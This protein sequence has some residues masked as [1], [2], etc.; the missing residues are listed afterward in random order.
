MTMASRSIALMVGFVLVWILTEAIIGSLLNAYSPLQIVWMHYLMQ[1]VIWGLV[2]GV[3]GPKRLVRTGKLTFQFLRAVMLLMMP[4]SWA[5]ARQQ[6]FGDTAYAA[7]WATPFLV[8]LFTAILSKDR[9]PAFLWLAAIAGGL[10]AGLI[11][12]Q[13]AIPHARALAGIIGMPVSFSLFIVLTRAL[14]TEPTSA[15]LFYLPLG[16]VACLMP[17]IP[18]VWMA[19]DLQHILFFM[20]TGGMSL[21]ALWML[22]KAAKTAPVAPVAPLLLAPIPLTFLLNWLSTHQRPG[23]QV[24]ILL[25]IVCLASITPI[26]LGFNALRKRLPS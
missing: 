11:F 2:V 22:D 24:L 16:I 14:K 26:L 19:P 5:F 23:L 10:A 8:I 6:G 25:A 15:N 12:V 9:T 13:P 18:K 3:R 21:V 1:L 7:F 17:F 4:L 20:L